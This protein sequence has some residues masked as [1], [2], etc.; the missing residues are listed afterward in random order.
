MRIL[1]SR[2][3]FFV[4]CFLLSF[5]VLPIAGQ[6]DKPKD[7]P[8]KPAAATASPTPAATPTPR[9]AVSKPASLL[10]E[11]KFREIGPA[12]MGGR[13]DDI[14][15]VPN[16]SR[17]IYVALAAGGI[18]KSIN[19]GT[20]WTTLFDK[21]AVPSVGD[22]AITPSNPSIIWAG[23]G[24]S[25]NRQSSS[26]GNGI[27]KSMDAGKTW[28]YMGLAD[29]HHIGRVVVHPTNPDIVYVAAAGNLWGPS[30]ERG[31]YRTMD[32]GKTW[33]LVLKVNDD[34]GASDIAMDAESP[35]I[36]Y[37]AMY[38]R[39]RTVFGFNGSGEG[40]ALYKTIDGGE[41]W[42]K[43]YDDERLPEPGC[44]ASILRYSTE[45]D[46]GKNRLLFSN[47]PNPGP[48]ID[49]TKLTVK[50]SYDE[51]QTWPVSRRIYDGP[52]AYSCLTV[53]ADGTIGLLY[54][55][56]S[57]HPYEKITFAQFNLEWLTSSGLNES[58]K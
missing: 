2:N 58:K 46:G 23:T 41:T 57:A 12:T 22:I 34:T 26:W 18:L 43:E 8:K 37:A 16:D 24:E 9:P 31:V 42:Y 50:L 52:T 7:R 10:G 21:E 51:G 36:L 3:G 29:T 20:S 11:L 35:T 17:I 4:F 44:Q 55:T 25:N 19:G 28:K 39:R 5:V 14:E 48:W 54:E 45:S 40:S 53:L 30:P 47:P 49:R 13:I 15:V 6:E 56:G 27:Y 33:Q 1:R 38:Q 32:G